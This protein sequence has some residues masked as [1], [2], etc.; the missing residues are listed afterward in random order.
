MSNFQ[1]DYKKFKLF[2]KILF[3]LKYNHCCRR[4]KKEPLRISEWLFM[5]HPSF[6]VGKIGTERE[7]L[8]KFQLHSHS[9][10]DLIRNDCACFLSIIHHI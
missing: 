6:S 5:F 2:L 9:H 3:F 8:R 10:N 4:N 7:D 1:K